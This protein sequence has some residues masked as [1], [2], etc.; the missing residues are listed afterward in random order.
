MVPAGP[1]NHFWPFVDEVQLKR[2]G[3][4]LKHRAPG[5]DPTLPFSQEA[6]GTTAHQEIFLALGRPHLLCLG[7]VR[8]AGRLD[9]ITPMAGAAPSCSAEV[10]GHSSAEQS[11]LELPQGET[12]QD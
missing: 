10:G 2:G 12:G 5:P 1:T 8:K 3:L 11:D 7:K 4:A 9:S 6:F